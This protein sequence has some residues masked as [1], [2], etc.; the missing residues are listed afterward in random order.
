MG[1]RIDVVTVKLDSSTENVIMR[2]VGK[3]ALIWA[4]G[5]ATLSGWYH[6]FTV[7]YMFTCLCLGLFSLSILIYTL[8][9]F[10]RS[11][12]STKCG[13]PGMKGYHIF[14]THQ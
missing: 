3:L 2:Q 1:N 6:G 8:A 4:G 5:Q 10:I 12:D 9:Q 7:H 13:L 14:N 11:L